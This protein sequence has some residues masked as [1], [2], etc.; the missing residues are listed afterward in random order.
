MTAKNKSDLEMIMKV[1][2]EMGTKPV[3]VIL[4]MTNPTVV[5]EFE[6]SIDALLINF[7]VQDQAILDVISGKYEP[8]GLLPLQMPANMETVET[9]FEDVPLD[10]VPYKDELGNH[11]DFG[12]GM[13]WSGRIEDE[14]NK[15]YTGKGME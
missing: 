12:F 8:T 15:R 5:A 7:G 6:E 1:R 4:K 13:N 9:Q 2:A 11:Y 3:V 14:R 10:M